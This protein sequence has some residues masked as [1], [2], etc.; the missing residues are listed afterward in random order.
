M[1]TQTTGQ[2]PRLPQTSGPGAPPTMGGSSGGFFSGGGADGKGN[3]GTLG[4]WGGKIAGWF[5]GGGG[6]GG[7]GQG[8]G[9][10]SDVLQ[11]ILQGAGLVAG[12]VGAYNA[13]KQSG[14]SSE[15]AGAAAGKAGQLADAQAAYGSELI[16]GQRPIRQRSEAAM[17]ERLDTGRRA[18]TSLAHLT[19][20]ANPFRA[21][22][23]AA[24][25]SPA[26]SPTPGAPEAEPDRLAALRNRVRAL[27]GL[28]PSL[29]PR[30]PAQ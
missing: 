30:M 3:L 20:T 8:Q 17:L 6:G 18:P 26:P 22:F 12:T 11:K 21:N 13:W 19:D 4:D 2:K 15:L 28:P 10:G 7:E 14:K 16:A 1:A 5:G 29:R 27:G 25:P 23:Q 9:G 24:P